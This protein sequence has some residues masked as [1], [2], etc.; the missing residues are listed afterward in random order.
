MKAT[1]YILCFFDVNWSNEE[2][3][4]ILVFQRIFKTI[5]GW[6]TFLSSFCAIDVKKVLKWLAIS[7]SFVVRALSIR[8]LY[9][10]LTLAFFIFSGDLMPL[11]IFFEFV[12]LFSMKD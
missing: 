2:R 11:H 6:G 7:F 1:Y 9:I 8:R 12:L 3:P 5:V 4:I 10:L